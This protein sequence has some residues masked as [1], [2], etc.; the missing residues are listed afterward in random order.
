M[1]K[2][3][4]LTP[5]LLIATLLSASCNQ[6]ESQ[7][8]WSSPSSEKFPWLDY[9]ANLTSERNVELIALT[10]HEQSIQSLARTLFLNSEVARKLGITNI[11]FL[12][13]PAELWPS[14]I[15][16]ASKQGVSIDLVYGAGPT[17]ANYLDELGYLMP[18]N[19]AK[20]PEH[21]AIIYEL[22]K[23]PAK[24]AGADTYK[25]DSEGN[26]KWIGEGLSGFGFTVNYDTL[27]KYGL[28]K[29]KTWEDLASPVYARYLPDTP[30][31]G[32]ADPT[33]STSN[34]RIFEI[35]LQAKGW[36]EGWRILTLMA[37]NA[38]IYPGSGDARDAVIRGDVAVATTIDFYG[39]MAMNVNPDC[40][41]IAP[42]GETM[43]NADAVAILNTTKHPVHAAAF[44]A[45]ALSEFGGQQVWLDKDINRI[46]VNPN[47]FNTPEGQQRP[48][49]K[50]SYDQLKTFRGIEFNETLSTMWVN[51]VV[52]YFK[53][54]LV[55][56]HDDLQAV[57]ARVAGAYLDGRISR[58]W[59]D[60]LTLE[61]SKPLRFKDPVTGSNV[62][63][64]QEYAVYI[65]PYLTKSEV[66][67]ALMTAW[68]SGARDRYRSVLSLL[69]RAL[70]GEPVPTTIT[71]TTFTTSTASTST[72]IP[73]THVESTTI[74]STASSTT[75]QLPITVNTT[76]AS[77]PSTT[78]IPSL[79]TTQSTASTALSQT[80]V[81]LL[82]ASLIIIA[83]IIVVVKR[84]K[85]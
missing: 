67:Q 62:E 73:V 60:Y 45:W 70:R 36:S 16:K 74:G 54:T 51:A 37:A 46:P 6:L 39:Y 41:Y 33:M 9:L 5:I 52:Y 85:P 72:S 19:P 17:L 78:V 18:I 76:P 48:D 28:P 7:Y 75:T 47:T 81:I 44:I 59:F 21:Y 69:E 38:R 79:S 31:I 65:N 24:I 25:K 64:T 63:F 30:L 20:R 71:G 10:R 12:Y 66:Y 13:V 84:G 42:E 40:E 82:A 35:I 11:R 43:V 55:D 32:T 83:L 2:L 4:Y 26:I 15:E 8:P 57:W 56:A 58:D 68:S 3:K 23:L 50:Q 53:A 80:T 61:L 34:T 14:Y 77:S 27:S 1:F 49:L 22:N 29:P